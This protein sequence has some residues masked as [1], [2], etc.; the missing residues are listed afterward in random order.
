M[1]TLLSS[2]GTVTKFLE[3]Y[4]L[5]RIRVKTLLHAEAPLEEDITPL[6]IKK[7]GII[8]RRRVQMFGETTN[9]LYGLAESFIRAD[10]LWPEVRGDLVQGR[11]GIGELMRERRIETYRE[12]LG[13]DSGP[14]GPWAAELGC[15]EDAA[16]AVRTYRIF[17]AGQP[18]L[19][20]T[21]RY[22]IA[23]FA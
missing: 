9:R 3:A 21:D 10:I 13:C 2:D 12:L 4:Y 20:I 22:V 5:E 19:L 23:H 8:L 17:V 15:S 11:L 1:R 7:G 6:E 16:T 14:A 18:C